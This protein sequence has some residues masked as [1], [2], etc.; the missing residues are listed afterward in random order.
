[1]QRNQRCS[2]LFSEESSCDLGPKAAAA[3]AVILDSVFGRKAAVILDRKQQRSWILFSKNGAIFE[4]N[5][6]GILSMMVVVM[7]TMMMTLWR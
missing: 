1:L 4:L 2:I 5:L 3:A 6:G 7:M